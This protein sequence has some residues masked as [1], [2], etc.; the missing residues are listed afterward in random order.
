MS[1]SLMGTIAIICF[2]IAIVFLIVSV[3]LFFHYDIVTIYNFLNGKTAI[4]EI[5]KLQTKSPT[6]QFKNRINIV[7]LEDKNKTE[8]IDQE[9]IKEESVDTVVLQGL[10]TT[11]LNSETIDLTHKEIKEDIQFELEEEIKIVYTKD[12]ISI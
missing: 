8:K 10:D 12:V 4:R 5:E 7:E 3:Y 1:A 6:T 11:V 2:V 9:Y